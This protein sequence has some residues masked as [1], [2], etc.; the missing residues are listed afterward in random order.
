MKG[1]NWVLDQR[2]MLLP[3]DPVPRTSIILLSV[4]GH[5]VALALIAVF[6]HATGAHIL[7]EQYATVQRISGE[8]PLPFNSTSSRP[9]LPHASPSHVR[10]KTRQARIPDTVTAAGVASAQA[11]RE[12][13]KQETAGLMTSIKF[14]QV[15][16]FSPNHDYQLAF[17]TEGEIPSIPAADVPPHFEQYVIVEVIIDADG[18]VAQ[19]RIVAGMV[20]PAIEQTLLSAI[21][22]FKYSPAKRDGT[23]IPSQLDIVIHIPS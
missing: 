15:Y 22:K 21:R 9:A 6:W 4:F 13:A 1:H 17:R 10:R 11:L 2:Q 16:G 12:R 20:D 14:R 23:P 3:N 7:R 18:R 8:A 5:L 19:E